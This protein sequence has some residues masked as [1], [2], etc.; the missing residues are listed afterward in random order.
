MSSL[1]CQL[2]FYQNIRQRGGMYLNF[3]VLET[4][5]LKIPKESSKSGWEKS[6]YSAFAWL[7]CYVYSQSYSH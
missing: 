7:S 6:G 5:K 4:Q 2:V 3:K 1:A